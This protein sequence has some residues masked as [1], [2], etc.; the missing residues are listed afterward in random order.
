MTETKN[1]DVI[2]IENGEAFLMSEFF[3]DAFLKEFGYAEDE[4]NFVFDP[5]NGKYIGH[6]NR[7]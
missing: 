6:I 4:N 3:M 5:F 2:F 7:M 1:M